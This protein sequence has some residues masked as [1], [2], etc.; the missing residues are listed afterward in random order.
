MLPDG[1]R[2]IILNVGTLPR[3]LVRIVG[4]RIVPRRGHRIDPLLAGYVATLIKIDENGEMIVRPLVG[5]PVVELLTGVP[6]NLNDQR[7]RRNALSD[8]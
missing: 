8:L 4:L 1:L 3:A 6:D 7:P 2:S 5:P